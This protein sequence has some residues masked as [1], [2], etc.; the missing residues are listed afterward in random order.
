MYKIFSKI[1]DEFMESCDYD[2]WCELL[3]E[4]IVKERDETENILDLGCGTGELLKRISR[5]Y[6]CSGLDISKEMIEKAKKKINGATFFLG[7]MRVFNTLEKYDV[8]FSFFDTIN[9]L[10]SLEELLDTFNSVSN[11]L[12]KNGIY[13][14]DVVDRKFM[15]QMFK[16]K[17]LIEERDEFTLIW[18]HEIDKKKLLDVIK[19]RY[20][21][22]N[23]K[24]TYDKYHE[25]YEKK[26]FSEEEIKEVIKFT[27]LKLEKILKND[28][29]AGE[30]YFYILRKI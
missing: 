2:K 12:R 4:I 10:K 24:G 5:K 29:L 17:I 22:K 1:Y 13:I 7:D 26:I 28:Y 9:H 19:A 3:E 6:K 15:K 8:I 16:E 27:D 30:R 18:E 23:K 14:F 25:I 11:C 21:I 20:F